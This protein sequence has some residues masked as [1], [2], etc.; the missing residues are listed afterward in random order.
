MTRF[1]NLDFMRNLLFPLLK[2]FKYVGSPSKI[3]VT[4]YVFT[5]CYLPGATP[6]CYLLNTFKMICREMSTQANLKTQELT[7]NYY[8]KNVNTY[9]CC[10]SA[11]AYIR[12]YVTH[13]MQLPLYKF[14]FE[15]KALGTKR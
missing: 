14:L 5:R 4:A 11:L 15:N 10:K 12:C 3:G 13:N 1:E 2:N 7:A 9:T 8:E 6:K